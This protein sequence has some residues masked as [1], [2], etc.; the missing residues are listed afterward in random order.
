MKKTS[1]PSE[2]E[3]RFCGKTFVKEKTLAVHM[4]ESKRRYMQKNERRVQA[5]FYVYN[6]FYKLT[7]NSKNEKTYEDFCKSPYYNAFVKFGSF[8]SNVNPLYPDKYIDWIIKSG[9]AL[10]KW[11]REELYDK[12]VLELIKSENVESASERTIN[13]MC[14]WA[15]K[16][17]ASWS[18]YFSYANLNRITYDVRDGKISPW[19]LLNSDSGKTSLKKMND[20]QLNTISPMIDIVFWSEKFKI[21][22]TDL[23]FVKNIIKEAK[24]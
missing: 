9:V 3:C 6:K 14:E 10:D 24:L 15:E 17:S 2:F 5:G 19:I 7:Q 22:K 4:C 12:Y 13:T 16:N 18:H 23:E 1:R 20:E 11:C 21:N 8:M